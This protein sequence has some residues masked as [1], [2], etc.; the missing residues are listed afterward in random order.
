MS[1][2]IYCS[3]PMYGKS[4]YTAWCAMLG[5]KCYEVAITYSNSYYSGVIAFCGC[6]KGCSSKY[7]CYDPARSYCKTSS[8]VYVSGS[9]QY[10]YYTPGVCT[11]IDVYNPPA[12]EQCVSTSSSSSSDD[13]STS[14]EAWAIVLP[15]L[16]TLA[17]LWLV[18]AAVHPL[19]K[20]FLGQSHRD[21]IERQGFA[22]KAFVF[23]IQAVFAILTTFSV[24]LIV[25]INVS[26]V[27]GI[28]NRSQVVTCASLFFIGWLI[29]GIPDPVLAAISTKFAPALKILPTQYE[30][31]ETT[32]KTKSVVEA[33]V[34]VVENRSDVQMVAIDEK[35]TD[36]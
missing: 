14:S 26:N 4:S 32:D 31:A 28:P 6:R 11:A 1:A 24:I 9:Y 33:K 34:I 13:S 15:I 18:E 2:S 20:I 16:L 23:P 22:V 27:S 35:Q 29:N 5:Q 30:K 25:L 36:V 8:L 10:T 7:D 12:I 19:L 21:L 3:T 17:I